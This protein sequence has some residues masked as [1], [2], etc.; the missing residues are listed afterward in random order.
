M[1]HGSWFLD[2]PSDRV[3]RRFHGSVIMVHDPGFRVYGSTMTM[4]LTLTVRFMKGIGYD[5]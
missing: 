3:E 2:E 5:F 4:T 1:V